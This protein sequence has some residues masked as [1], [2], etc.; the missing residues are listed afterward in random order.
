LSILKAFSISLLPRWPGCGDGG[1]G[2]RHRA[3]W[4]W[5]W[6]ALVWAAAGATAANTT[7]APAQ[8]T[9]PPLLELQV[10]S[11]GRRLALNRLGPQVDRRGRPWSVTRLDLLLSDFALQRPDGRW[12]GPADWHGFF[13]AEQP[14][15]RE[16]L[17]GVS[18]GHY[19]AVRFAV[20]VPPAANHRDPHLLPPGHPL[21]PLVNGLHWNWRAGY[22]FLALEGHWRPDHAPA[23]V[24]AG[25]S[26]HVGDDANRVSVQRPVA[27]RVR[28]GEVLRLRLDIGRL[29]A[30][31]DIARDGESTH[32]RGPDPVVRALKA[33]LPGAF[34]LGT[35]G[36]Q[37]IPGAS[38]ATMPAAASGTA[39]RVPYP[40]ALG[41]HLPT[42]AWPADNPLT[43][44]GVALGQRLFNDR[45]LS[46]DGQLSCASCHHPSHAFSDPGKALSTG[47]GGRLG[48]RNTMPLFNLAWVDA[49]FWDGRSQALRQQVLEPIQHPHEMAESLPRVVARLAADRLLADQFRQAFGGPPSAERIGLAL[50]Q[51]LLSLVSQDSRFDRVMRGA[52]QF[53]ASERRGFELFLTEHDPQRG[54]MGADCFHCHGGALFTSHRFFNNGLAPRPGDTGREQVTGDPADRGKFRTPSLRN[55]SAT[56]PYMH[57]G[58]FKTLEEVID[59]YDRGVARSDTLDPNL[60]KHPREGLRL[61]RDD[62]AALLDFLRTL[63][64]PAFVPP[65]GTSGRHR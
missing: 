33:G 59:H 24:T 29:L 13:R 19:V 18:P 50:E 52:E 25:H 1:A 43:V 45:R 20:G 46:R 53:S 34:S 22:V 27:L 30:D 14:A 65:A 17:A 37:V 54:L 8:D 41:I 62:K 36:Q 57:D 4:T 56:A 6:A 16:V 48:Q 2:P 21:H 64:D 40:M 58:R 11:Q 51:Y 23:G 7:A 9:A 32:S 39:G 44:A 60:A 31:V 47:V 26:Y 63:D 15:R 42:P 49:F 5:T 12:V 10:L 38:A 28:A 61:S 35:T 3:R 55:L